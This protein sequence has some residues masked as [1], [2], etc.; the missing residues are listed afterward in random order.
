[1]KSGILLFTAEFGGMT[2][3][4]VLNAALD[5]AATAERCGYDEAWI[6]EH[7]FI[8]NGLCEARPCLGGDGLRRG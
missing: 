3:G 1:M 7:H 5:Y 6:T 2:H 4:E 8:P